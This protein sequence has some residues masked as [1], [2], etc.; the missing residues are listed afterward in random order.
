MTATFQEFNRLKHKIVEISK[1]PHNWDSYG[2]E[3]PNALALA[4]ADVT[5]NLLDG[6]D[7][8][9]SR[10]AAT[11]ECGVVISWWETEHFDDAKQY[12]DIE[13][14][15]DGGIVACI[16]RRDGKPETWEVGANIFSIGAS[17]NKIKAF[18]TIKADARKA[19]TT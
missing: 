17:V 7:F 9:P 1:L 3:P 2:A 14:L 15:N 6:M 5:L 10:V 12:A 8:L 13:F 19:A 4:R 16:S 11:V 18:V